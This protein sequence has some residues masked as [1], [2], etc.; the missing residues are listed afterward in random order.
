[1]RLTVRRQQVVCN[2]ARETSSSASCPITV[3]DGITSLNRTG[4]CGDGSDDSIA[5]SRL[6]R[7]AIRNRIG[8]FE[9]IALME[10]Q[11]GLTSRKEAETF[12]FSRVRK[13]PRLVLELFVDRLALN[14]MSFLVVDDDL[15]CGDV[16][17]GYQV[18][19]HLAIDSRTLLEQNRSMLDGTYCTSVE[20]YTAMKASGSLGR[21]MVACMQQ[22]IG[23]EMINEEELSLDQNRPRANYFGNQINDDPFPDPNLIGLEA[24]HGSSAEES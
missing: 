12:T 10:I 15:S 24:F 19:H 1:M 11:V 18:L 2:L 6:A 9:A 5:S 23:S 13:V 7:T 8:R 14:N 4:R 22:V 17:A 16:L 21:L 20:H 3:F